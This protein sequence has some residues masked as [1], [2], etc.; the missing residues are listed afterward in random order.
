MTNKNI[1]E[2]YAD[3]I[4]YGIIGDKQKIEHVKNILTESQRKTPNNQ[5]EYYNLK[6]I[7][8]LVLYKECI[9]KYKNIQIKLD[10][11]V[12]EAQANLFASLNSPSSYMLVVLRNNNGEYVLEYPKYQISED[13]D[14]ELMIEKEFS[15]LSNKQLDKLLSK[16]IKPIAILGPNRDVILYTS[17][18]VTK[19]SSSSSSS[20]S[21]DS[22]VKMLTWLFD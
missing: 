6:T 8:P 9:E 2:V 20:N 18:L 10:P 5:I 19:N 17:K 14:P 22:S 1:I 12:E 11:L 7:I 16:T 21:P 15:N 4:Y 13:K 3:Y